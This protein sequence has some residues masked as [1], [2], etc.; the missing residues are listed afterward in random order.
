MDT[1]VLNTVLFLIMWDCV[2]LARVRIEC[3]TG[4]KA[5]ILL[6]HHRIELFGNIAVIQ[7]QSGSTENSIDRRRCTWNQS[8]T[9]YSCTI[10]EIPNLLVGK[11]LMASS[12]LS[13]YVLF[14]TVT[15]KEPPMPSFHRY[16]KR[17]GNAV[18]YETLTQI[19][20]YLKCGR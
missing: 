17:V 19:S 10:G 2:N 13:F 16:L 14:T 7:C 20:I 5:S 9:G 18:W 15:N 4:T 6:G 12:V 8:Q 1:I 11:I 3:L